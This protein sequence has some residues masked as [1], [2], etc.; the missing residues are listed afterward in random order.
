MRRW[1]PLLALVSALVGSVLLFFS[2]QAIPSS[3][4]I[5]VHVDGS[6]TNCVGDKRVD[7]PGTYDAPTACPPGVRHPIAMVT[8]NLGEWAAYLGFALV[9]FSIV[10]Q[11]L[12]AWP[13]PEDA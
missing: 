9:I 7:V 10:V 12:I 5:I 3:E 1:L 6:T 13:R 2:F 4:A 8:E 11:G